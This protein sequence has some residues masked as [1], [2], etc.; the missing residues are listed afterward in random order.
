MKGNL[1]QHLKA[2]VAST[3]GVLGLAL[4]LGALAQGCGDGGT[5][6]TETSQGGPTVTSTMTAR[7][8]IDLAAPVA[9]QT[10]SFAL[11]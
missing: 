8:L 11:G 5:S 3:A 2:A 10:A 7:P 4:T 1:H 9:F 6:T